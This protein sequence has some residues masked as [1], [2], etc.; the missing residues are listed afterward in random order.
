M[1][2]DFHQILRRVRAGRGEEGDYYFVYQRTAGIQQ[3][4]EGGMPG[5]ERRF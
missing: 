5:L 2:G 4:T 1:A 3:L